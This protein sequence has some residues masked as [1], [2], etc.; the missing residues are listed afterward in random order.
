MFGM[1]NIS[2]A[3]KFR[4]SQVGSQRPP[5]LSH[6]RRQQ[7]T[8]IPAKRHIRPPAALSSDPADLIHT[9]AV[10]LFNRLM[11]DRDDYP[12]V[13]AVIVTQLVSGDRG[14]AERL[15]AEIAYPRRTISRRP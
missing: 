3:K 5:I 14:G 6:T 7:P 13:I 15:V 9:Q 12:E 11:P 2:R 1:S 10:L 8:I 4:G